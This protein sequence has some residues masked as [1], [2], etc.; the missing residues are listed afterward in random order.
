MP[1]PVRWAGIL[2]IAYGVIQI[3]STAVNVVLA[4]QQA[5]QP[6]VTPQVGCG[7]L[8]GLAFG[9]VGYQTVTGTAKDTLGNAIG[10]LGLGLC[11]AGI[12]ALLLVGRQFIGQQQNLDQ[13]ALLGALI[14][15]GLSTAILLVAGVLALAGRADYRAWRA[16][17][18]QRQ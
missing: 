10:S 12:L 7:L 14:G 17:R 8:F 6:A 9:Y 5:G 2:W 4:G 15:A 11:A 16:A 1:A 18:Q 3:L 13:G